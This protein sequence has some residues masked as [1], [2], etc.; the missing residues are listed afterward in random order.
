MIT[1]ESRFGRGEVLAARYSSSSC[2]SASPR[3]VSRS[4]V[5]ILRIGVAPRSCSI[6]GRV[7]I[8]T[9]PKLRFQPSWLGSLAMRRKETGLGELQSSVRTRRIAG[10]EGRGSC[11]SCGTRRCRATSGCIFGFANRCGMVRQSSSSKDWSENRA[12]L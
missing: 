1:K 12:Q 6:S 5:E 9:T 3:S 10:V 2:A 8:W 11:P 7:W 4:E